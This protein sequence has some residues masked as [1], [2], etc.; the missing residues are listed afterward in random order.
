MLCA[1]TLESA[2]RYLLGGRNIGKLL[3][4]IDGV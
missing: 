1:Y 2:F 3:T 4:D